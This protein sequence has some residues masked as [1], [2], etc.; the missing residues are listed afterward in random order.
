VHPVAAPLA[1]A[2]VLALAAGRGDD[3]ASE[4]EDEAASLEGVPW[5]LSS[6]LD[7]EGGSRP[8]RA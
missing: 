4:S 6:G 1:L 2:L 8:L 7:V 3:D 5:V